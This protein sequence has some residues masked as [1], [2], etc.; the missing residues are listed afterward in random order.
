MDKYTIEQL[1]TKGTKIKF[2]SDVNWHC[3]KWEKHVNYTK[4]RLKETNLI[5]HGSMIWKNNEEH[6]IVDAPD[7]KSFFYLVP[8]SEFERLGMLKSE[9]KKYT[10]DYLKSN[11]VAIKVEDE[12]QI[13]SLISITKP[14][15]I[16]NWK[17]YF[18]K[19]C[20]WFARLDDLHYD[21]AINS[22]FWRDI[23]N[24]EIIDYQT[25]I[26][27]NKQEKMNEIPQY[28]CVKNDGTEEFKQCIEW[29]N[30]KYE[31]NYGGYF[32]NQYYGYDGSSYNK[33]T[34]H[35]V[36]KNDFQNN[37]VVF[38]SAKEF[39]EL[40]NK[41]NKKNT[42][43][44]PQTF[45]ILGKEHQL[46]AI[47][48]DLMDMGYEESGSPGWSSIGQSYISGIYFKKLTHSGS[49]DA[50]LD[51][52]FNLPQDYSK[53]LEHAQKCLELLKPKEIK[54]SVGGKFDVKIKDSKIWHNS[55]DITSFVEEMVDYFIGNTNSLKD[56][57]GFFAKTKEVEFEYTGCQRVV[58]KLSDWVELWNKYKEITK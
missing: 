32:N 29:L 24:Y 54:H 8:I 28:F 26:E 23:D 40:V 1:R 16:E 56:F 17:R 38:E 33:G 27:H 10:I 45:K 5:S 48:Q 2:E 50:Q 51:V 11:K 57:G 18:H 58:T 46:K 3:E 53:A 47:W 34:Y 55:S 12:K 41:T 36:D 31:V 15:K 43:E 4:L 20:D 42:M 9:E 22:V 13:E 19:N 21:F 52:T 39:M 30:S 37:P 35:T 7:K 14:S 25:F 44:K 49:K 6:I